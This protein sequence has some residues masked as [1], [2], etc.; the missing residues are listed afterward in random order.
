ML[1]NDFVYV[2]GLFED[3]VLDIADATLT[4]G[5]TVKIG[6]TVVK[7]AYTL[8]D[9]GGTPSGIDVTPLASK[10]HLEK[11]GVIEQE[12][13]EVSYIYNAADFAALNALK[14]ATSSSPIEVAFPNGTKFTNTGIVAANFITS[15]QVNNRGEAKAV[16][17]LS[18]EW[19]YVPAA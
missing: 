7:W 8:G 13:W 17:N 5:V 19:T 15:P 12:Q 1:M 4:V 14:G 6:E 11:S 2:K 9:L 16:I 18:G 3:V 10:V